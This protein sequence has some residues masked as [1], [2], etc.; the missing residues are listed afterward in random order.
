MNTRNDLAPTNNCPSVHISP[1]GSRELFGKSARS[2]RH[3]LALLLEAAQVR[4]GLN[5]T[6]LAAALGRT[7]GN[8]VPGS[9]YPR[10][11]FIASLAQLLSWTIEDLAD[12]ITHG[13]STETD[14]QEVSRATT[15][16]ETFATFESLDEYVV[17]NSLNVNYA[18]VRPLIDQLTDLARTPEQRA[19]A[20]IRALNISVADGWF[21][22]AIELARAALDEQ[23][24]SSTTEAALN[25]NLASGYAGLGHPFECRAFADRVVAHYSSCRPDTEGDRSMAAFGHF[26]AAESDRIASPDGCLST[27]SEY[28]VAGELFR[29]LSLDYGSYVYR[30]MEVQCAARAWHQSAVAAKL[31]TRGAIDEASE[32]LEATHSEGADLE[33]R[34]YWYLGA[35][36]IARLAPG[37][38]RPK[39]IE[40]LQVFMSHATEI[41][42]AKKNWEMRRDLA[43]LGLP[44]Q[45]G[46][47]LNPTI[48]ADESLSLVARFPS[49][50]YCL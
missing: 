11:D 49:L 9:G 4:N 43:L 29:Q 18:T 42:R 45:T 21:A 36:E 1:T 8:L 17:R 31:D 23:Q 39:E 37:K 5:K 20:R 48:T 14:P 28:K 15:E 30:D 10:I 34:A 19:K 26:L 12:W 7:R 38:V 50:R 33:A 40:C 47:A 6:S 27:S 46:L 25:V 16:N 13:P 24:L 44:A 22:P 41:A 2:T 35:I 3:R 32:I